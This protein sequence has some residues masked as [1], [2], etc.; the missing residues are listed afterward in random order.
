MVEYSVRYMTKSLTYYVEVDISQGTLEDVLKLLRKQ[1]WEILHAYRPYGGRPTIWT[2]VC[3][4]QKTY[5]DNE[6]DNIWKTLI[7]GDK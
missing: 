3:R 5:S 1:D 4:K 6:L 7:G 2:I